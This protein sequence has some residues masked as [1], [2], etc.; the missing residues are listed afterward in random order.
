M[1][2]VQNRLQQLSGNKI[3]VACA[4]ALTLGACS[5]KVGVLRS[6]DQRGKAGTTVTPENKADSSKTDEKPKDDHVKLDIQ[7]KIALILPFQLDKVNPAALS[8]ADIQRSA[9][10]LDFYQGFQLALDEL[11][12]QGTVFG[13]SVVDSKDDPASNVAIARS[14]N[15]SDASLIVGP[16]YPKEIQAFGGNLENKNTLQINPLAATKAST[17]NLGNLV[18][19]TP[20][21]DVHTKATAERVA[22]EFRSGDVVIVYNSSDN[23][24]RQFLA[25]FVG[26]LKGINPTISLVSVSSISQLNEQLST[27]GANLIVAGTTDKF[28]LRTFLD[29]LEKKT[30]ENFYTFKLFGHPLW[31]RIDFSMYASFSSFKPTITSADHLMPWNSEVKK[32]KDKYYSIY[33][34]NPSDHSY[35]GYDAAKYFGKLL[36]KY[37]AEYA[38]KVVQEEYKGVFSSYK[39]EFSE[40]GGFVNQS[41]SYRTYKGSGFELN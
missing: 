13:L 21:I 9:V 15:I 34:V 28:Q 8:K 38:S 27:T 2:S 35:K 29:N 17:F 31:D 41:V 24:S 18:S 19:L 33:G 32:L 14:K 1:I 20:S 22:K 4:C 26:E 25:G 36:N 11:A 39:F 37:G 23:N 6:P 10:A 16:V 30:L 7:N 3:L 12:E 40:D 5:P